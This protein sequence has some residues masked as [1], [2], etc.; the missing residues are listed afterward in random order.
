MN[1]LQFME[2]NLTVCLKNPKMFLLFDQAVPPLKNYSE[3][4]NQSKTK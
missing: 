1:A 3:S 2:S 4:R